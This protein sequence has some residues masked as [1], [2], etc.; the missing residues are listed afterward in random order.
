MQFP[1]A[2]VICGK[3]EYMQRAV[4]NEHFKI[5]HLQQPF[6]FVIFSICLFLQSSNPHPNLFPVKS[7]I[8]KIL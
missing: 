5:A 6:F 8:R 4:A 1:P 3:N 7:S 2:V